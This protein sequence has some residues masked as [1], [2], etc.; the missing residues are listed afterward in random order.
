MLVCLNS[1]IQDFIF[2]SA[3]VKVDI[4]LF[5]DIRIF[6]LEFLILFLILRDFIFNKSLCKMYILADK[7]LNCRKS[8]IIQEQRRRSKKRNQKTKNILIFNLIFLFHKY[9]CTM[10][11]IQLIRFFFLKCDRH[12]YKVILYGTRVKIE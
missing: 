7:K 8:R 5:N 10:Y 2:N 12:T 9:F 3:R 6:L 1:I 4:F 11:K